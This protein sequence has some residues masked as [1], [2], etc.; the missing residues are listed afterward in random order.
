MDPELFRARARARCAHDG[1]IRD[2]GHI[3]A[4]MSRQR[5][6]PAPE[7]CARLYN[8]SRAASWDIVGVLFCTAEGYLVIR[9]GRAGWD[10]GFAGVRGNCHFFCDY[11]LLLRGC[12]VGVNVIIFTRTINVSSV[13]YFEF[14]LL[15]SFIPDIFVG[16]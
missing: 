12:D 9:D 1:S 16:E 8:S 3:G 2:P 6:S 14:H 13:G 7:R 11:F 15:L 10:K 4:A 5:V